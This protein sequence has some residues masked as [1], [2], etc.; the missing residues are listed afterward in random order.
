MKKTFWT[1]GIIA[2]VWVACQ[3]ETGKG[4]V[5]ERVQKLEEE[6]QFLHQV[7]KA[8]GVDVERVRADIENANKV[9]DIPI[10][11][12]PVAG[13][14]NA[15]ITIVE[16][17]DFQCPYCARA[18]GMVKSIQEKYPD[19]VRV[20]FKHFPL[21][22]HTLSPPAHAASMA[23]KNQGKFWEYR[24]A[25]AP[26]FRDLSE[27]VFVKVADS[28]GLDI[29]KFKVDMKLDSTKNDIIATDMALGNDVGVRGTPSF[30]VNGK[31]AERFSPQMI[32]EMLAEKK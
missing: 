14:E 3:A 31:K 20:V 8:A 24:Y 23:A 9:H 29:E 7:F 13:P 6:V 30:Y 5:E 17:S 27:G 28:L 16:F 19:Q 11:D 22:F 32:D 21:S 10:G 2:A 18:S 1:I 4:S 26:H 25:L 15:K 12:S